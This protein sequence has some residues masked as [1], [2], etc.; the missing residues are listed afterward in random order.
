MS[1]PDFRGG[2]GRGRRR[3]PLRTPHSWHLLSPLQD[4]SR[5]PRASTVWHNPERQPGS[6]E[7]AAGASRAPRT[8]GSGPS[9]E[10]TPR[11]PPPPVRGKDH[12][13][14]DRARRGARRGA[15]PRGL[16]GLHPEP[17]GATPRVRSFC[18]RGGGWRTENVSLQRASRAPA[19]SQE[20]RPGKSQGSPGPPTPACRPSPRP[21]PR[22]NGRVSREG[23]DSDGLRALPLH[24]LQRQRERGGRRTLTKRRPSAGSRTPGARGCPVRRRRGREFERRSRKEPRLPAAPAHCQP[25]RPRDSGLRGSQR[26]AGS[27]GRAG[28][29]GREGGGRGGPGIFP[30]GGARPLQ[31]S[32]NWRLGG[33]PGSFAAL[34]AGAGVQAAAERARRGSPPAGGRARGPLPGSLR[35]PRCKHARGGVTLV[36]HT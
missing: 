6:P 15:P 10:S 36:S 2:R 23:G 29:S 8:R 31:E 30:V 35:A 24:R 4:M 12:T 9:R 1:Q 16:P 27:R 33:G 34:R 18:F 25:L 5:F 13:S 21:H 32:G 19:L 17:L 3:F 26:P 22:G 28:C 20:G 14:G 11:R 7:P